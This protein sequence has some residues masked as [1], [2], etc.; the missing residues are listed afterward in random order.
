MINHISKISCFV[1]IICLFIGCKQKPVSKRVFKRLNENTTKINFINTNSETDSLNI[2]DYL[3]FYNG[4][5]LAS[6]DFNND[7]LEDL[8][9]VSNQGDNKLYLNKGNLIFEDITEKAGVRGIGNWK[10]G[11][12]V[13]DLNGDGYQDIYLSVVDG[14]RDLNGKNQLFINNGDLTFTEKAA[15]YGIDF[16]G[17]STQAAFFDYDK[18]DDLDLFIL[19]HSVHKNNTYGDSSLRFNDNALAGDRLFQNN[20]GK[21]MDVSKQA[22]IYTASIGYGLGLSIGDL[23]NDGWDDIYVSNDFFEH[24]YYYINQKNGTFKEKL[25]EAFGHSSL[26]SM[27][28][29]MAD[30][31]KDGYLDVVSTDMLPEDIKVLKSTIPDE[32]PDI[33]NQEVKAGYHYQYSKNSLQLNVANGEKFVD[34]SL[35]AG[36]A[37][38]DWTWSPLVHDFDMDGE[39]DVFFSNGIKKRLNDLDYLK[40][41]GD[42]NVIKGYGKDRKFDLDKINRMPDGKVH[43]YLYAG[44]KNLKFTDVSAS[45]D[46]DNPSASAGAIAVDLDNDGDL[47]IVTNN[48]DEPAFIYQ[49]LTAQSAE[50]QKSPYLQLA[51]QYKKNNL[52]GIGTKVFFKTDENI[53]HQEI[54]TTSAF[55]SNQSKTL[56]FT[57]K[58][59]TSPK[60]I[61]IIWPD[62]NYQI[63]KNKESGKKIKV[64]YN[65]K[66]VSSTTAVTQLIGN[67]LADKQ[68][69]QS[70]KEGVKLLASV[71]PNTVPDFNYSFLLPH[72]YRLQ[73]PPIAVTDINNDGFDDIYIGGLEQQE[74]YILLS[75]KNGAFKKL[76]INA[77]ENALNLADESAAFADVDQDG[78]QDLLV[79]SLSHPFADSKKISSH[80]LY[81]NNANLSFTLKALPAIKSQTSKIVWFDFNNDGFTDVFLPAAVSYRDY[82]A[83]NAS[84]I[85]INDGKGNFKPS[86]EKEYQEIKS[87]AF[88]KDVSVQDIDGNKKNDLIIAAEWQPI[89]LFLNDGKNLKKQSLAEADKLNGWWQSVFVTDYNNDGKPD[90]LAGNW[91]LNAKFSASE[92][93]PLYAFNKDMDNDGRNDFILSYYN[94]GKYYP[95]RPKN[96]LE[97]EMPYMKKEWLSYQKMA[98]KTTEEIFKINTNDPS[99]LSVN[100][101]ESVL[102]D[103]VL[104][105]KKIV[106]LPYLYQ[107][108]PIISALQLANK[109][110][111]VNGNFWGVMPYEGKYDA[112]GLMTLNFNR[113]KNSFSMPFYHTNSAINFNEITFVET[114]KTGAKTSVLVLTNDGRLYQ[115]DI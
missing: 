5:G 111:L 54:Q 1:V 89:F 86:G 21:F 63:L 112:M 34:I 58:K 16:Q 107:Q 56:T 14:Y 24:D 32:S 69:V 60:E 11:A 93:N 73:T 74:K 8:Y 7:G 26:F 61:L 115:M 68:Q 96:D 29:A 43:N 13:V 101:F 71:K 41:L 52:D 113:Q 40:Y 22:G 114:L 79:S 45:N 91:G 76:P 17:L 31:N 97:M 106:K 64:V 59:Q 9:F 62:N 99:T 28:N 4:A 108:A 33:Y 87:I 78:D 39:K 65:A 66:T 37:A 38:T 104:G 81:I 10:N 102:I 77:F 44:S 109:Q 94:N 19:T 103:D 20:N 6:A 49:N 55:Q 27:G 67:F 70:K 84:Q 23:N 105:E 57:F 51:F 46:M 36:I 50:K 92:E 35:Y 3:Y 53:D 72:Q 88:I 2:L 110:L 85:W 95:F 98:D 42:P 90:L 15:E 47:E 75:D 12:T 48:M 83:K 80:R 100:S 30:I 25:K 18:D 82:S